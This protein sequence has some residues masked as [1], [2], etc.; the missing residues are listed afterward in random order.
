VP[1]RV[2]LASDQCL[3]EQLPYARRLVAKALRSAFARSD[4]ALARSDIL[5]A[6]HDLSRRIGESTAERRLVLVVSDMLENSSITSFYQGGQLRRIDAEGELK[7]V[8]AAGIHADFHGA[9]VVVIG[10]GIGMPGAGSG[11]NYRDPRA[12]LALE[13][14]WRRWFTGSNAALAEFGKP[15]PLVEIK[16]ASPK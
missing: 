1:K 10:A 7:R 5:T 8:A 16:W 12:M 15:T 3:D 4:P 13:D 14:F 11:L 2:L 9:Q 6:L